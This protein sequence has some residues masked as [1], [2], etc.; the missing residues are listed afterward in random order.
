MFCQ[1]CGAENKDNA[2]FCTK[3]GAELTQNK[4]NSVDNSHNN[5]TKITLGIGGAL[6]VIAGLLYSQGIFGKSNDLNSTTSD[7]N[8]VVAPFVNHEA[9]NKQLIAVVTTW[10]DGHNSKDL[11]VYNKL[12]DANLSFYTEAITKEKA[13]KQKK[14][15]FSKYPKFYQEL[16]GTPVC[17]KIDD[18]SSN[19]MCDFVKHISFDGKEKDYPSYLVIDSKN[20]LIVGESDLITDKNLKKLN[21]SQHKGNY[22]V[23]LA[24]NGSS[25]SI[26]SATETKIY[27]ASTD[28][29]MWI[30]SFEYMD[31]KTIFINKSTETYSQSAILNMDTMKAIDIDGG[32]GKVI[33]SGK[34]K[35]NF[36]T[37]SKRYDERDVEDPNRIGAYWYSAI[38]NKN[39]QILSIEGLNGNCDKNFQVSVSEILK[40]KDTSKLEHSTNG[41]VCVDY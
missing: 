21:M 38:R 32:D 25:I 10:N 2:N 3:C 30:N 20:M 22:L 12:Y 29:M 24:K 35:G 4:I 19:Y 40:G 15:L 37:T 28:N 39:N 34:Y 8:S 33:R 13:L 14:N 7:Q 1:K 9:I 23:T 41:Y 27:K 18:N 11:E 26:Q 5:T 17:N 6:I 36:L 31:N 16:L